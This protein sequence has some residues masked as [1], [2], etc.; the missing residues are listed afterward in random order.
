MT[1]EEVANF[2]ESHIAEEEEEN[3]LV[4]KV[5]SVLLTKLRKVI[6]ELRKG[7]LDHT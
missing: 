7:E 6:F 2:L 5:P 4:P 3:G 1:L